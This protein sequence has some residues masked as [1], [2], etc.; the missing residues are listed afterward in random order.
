MS[1]L[2]WEESTSYKGKPCMG[3]NWLHATLC[4]F[5]ALDKGVVLRKN[6]WMSKYGLLMILLPMQKSIRLLSAIKSPAP[7]SSRYV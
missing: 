5:C 3:E 4:E 2:F 1:V 7:K 6:F